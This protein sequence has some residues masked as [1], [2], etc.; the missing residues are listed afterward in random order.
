MLPGAI[1]R[2]HS[3]RQ[4]Q[5]TG[6]VTFTP[7]NPRP[8]AP[9]DVEGTLTVASFNML[10]YFDGIDT[11]SSDCGPNSDQDCRGADSVSEFTRQKNKIVAAIVAIDADIVGL[12]EIENNDTSSVQDLIDAINAIAGAGTYNFVD[13]GT[14]G[15]Y[16]IK[17]AFIYKPGTV[18]LVGSFAVL[19]D[20]YDANYHEEKNRPALAQ[21]FKEAGTNQKFTVVVNHFKFRDSDCNSLG[22]PDANDGQGNCNLTRISG[23]EVLVNW[24]SNDPTSSGDTDFLIIGALNCYAMEDPITAITNA[25]YTNLIYSYMGDDAYSYGDDGMWGYLDHALS[26]ST[27]TPQ[28]TGCTEWH[29]NSDEPTVL[30]YNEE[31]KSAGQ[32]TSLYNDDPYRASD[33][34]PVIIGLRLFSY[35]DLTVSLNGDGDGSVTS[36]PTGIDCESN[37]T[38]TYNHLTSV[39]LEAQAGIGSVF[40]GWSGS[41]TNSNETVYVRMSTDINCTAT[42]NIDSDLDGMPDSWEDANGLNSSLND[43]DLD[44]DGDGFSNIEEYRKGTDP[45]DPNSHP[46]DFTPL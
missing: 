7:A 44:L 4:L 36:Y 34:D 10:N 19:D 16:A 25:S 24:L 12:M 28:V 35:N 21:T 42:F 18:T 9:N 11:G 22:D 2:T 20:S 6:N 46:H 5:P 30:D 43:A 17:V 13:T 41:F 29:I 14:I 40:T 31:S 1:R 3:L 33:H 37:C 27:L 32:L 38:E 23:A 39:R 45:N 8:A 26:S 15:D